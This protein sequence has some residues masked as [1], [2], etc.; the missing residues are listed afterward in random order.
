MNRKHW[1]A[2]AILGAS[3]P[4]LAAIPGRPGMLNY[5]E[6]KAFLDSQDVTAQSVGSAVLSPGQTVQTDKGKVEV[7]L[8]PGVFL[9]LNNDS[10]V[11]MISPGLTDTQVE[12]T[13]GQA[14][15]EVTGL[16]KENNLQVVDR[17]SL[18]RIEKDGVYRFDADRPLVAVYDGKA[19]VERDDKTVDVKSGRAVDIATSAPLKAEKFDKNTAE[20]DLYKWSKL[21]SGYLSAA[22]A[23]AAPVY[24]T[25]NS[26]WTGPGWYWNPWYSSYTFIP[27]RGVL[28]SPFGWGFL[29][30]WSS[31]YGPFYGGYGYYP[32][33]VYGRP[34]IIGRVPAPV[35]RPG[36]VVGVRPGGGA[37]PVIRPGINPGR[38]G[39]RPGF[40]RPSHP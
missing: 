11:R 8:T 20:D 13:R 24:L 37:A 12:V 32:P 31:Y 19:K 9:R 40:I 27:G 23:V 17:G 4:M 29:S 16:Q 26:G 7:L 38:G 25:A 33:V 35:V 34:R 5:V 14:M 30:P 3:I 21:R 39:G 10:A 22:N 6:G 18:T 15:L 28:Y 36:P 1:A 2:V